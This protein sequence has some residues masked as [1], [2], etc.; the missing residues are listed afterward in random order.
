M[1]SGLSYEKENLYEKAVGLCL[2]IW[3]KRN[4]SILWRKFE[5]SV[6]S[7]LDSSESVVYFLKN[8]DFPKA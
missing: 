1:T 5:K 2:F 7:F 6:K 8:Q 4:V 3:Y